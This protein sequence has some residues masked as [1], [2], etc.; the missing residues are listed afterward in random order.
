[1]EKVEELKEKIE[2]WQEE[3]ET[4]WA[5]KETDAAEVERRNLR[6]LISNA[7]KEIEEIENPKKQTEL[8][9]SFDAL[10]KE[11]EDIKKKDA[12]KKL[13][14]NRLKNRIDKLTDERENYASLKNTSYKDIYD[15]YTK[16][17]EETE[18]E[19]KELEK[20][21]QA[22]KDKKLRA[23]TALRMEYEK[24]IKEKQ[25]E[26][27]AVQ[28]EIE[29]IEFGT[30]EAMVEKELSDG[31]KVKT[32][33][34]LEL[35][36]KKDELENTLKELETNKEECQAYIDQ[37]KGIEERE[38]PRELSAEEIKYFHG[39]G[40]V[41]E[42]TRDDRRANDE[43]FGFEK[44]KP[45]MRKEPGGEQKKDPNL[46]KPNSPEPNPTKPESKK[47]TQPTNIDWVKETKEKQNKENKAEVISKEE[48]QAKESLKYKNN[49]LPVK[50]EN[51]FKKAFKKIFKKT[52]TYLMWK[53]D[54]ENLKLE[55]FADAIQ[56]PY[57]I[58][59]N[60][61]NSNLITKKQKQKL[62]TLLD[63]KFPD[64]IKRGELSE[65]EKE[66]KKAMQKREKYDE[67]IK[68]KE[69]KMKEEGKT[70]IHASEQYRKSIRVSDEV[71]ENIKKIQEEKRNKP[72]TREEIIAINKIKENQIITKDATALED[73]IK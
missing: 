28:R 7:K 73:L 13:Q 38:E 2:K 30:E 34:I 10:K 12:D 52:A 48:N 31:T 69:D 51:I 46:G 45:G 24:Q 27:R 35:Y 72:K 1:M 21:P 50:K 9:N 17:I 41:V 22:E 56:S 40:D 37:I 62:S 25:K 33:K 65:D 55:D 39:Q 57:D 58:K 71:I 29:D 14:I 8:G 68:N 15:E 36:K 70:V 42:N 53:K 6:N 66:L 11:Y 3:L 26:I 54:V 60:I 32:P 4:V 5:G 59:N 18:K 23:I 63:S 67:Y 16:Q 61:N 47:I 19:I 49:N 20:E 44:V 64:K 43:Y